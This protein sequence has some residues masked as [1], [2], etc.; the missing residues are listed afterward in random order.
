MKP[1]D[2][3]K[4]KAGHPLVTRDG[5]KARLVGH[6][7]EA[8]E[9]YRVYAYIEGQSCAYSFW[10]SGNMGGGT[11]DEDLFMAPNKREGWVNVYGDCPPHGDITAGTSPAY[12]TKDIADLRAGST[13]SA[14]IRIEWEE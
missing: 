1:F 10:E 14:C 9:P 5:R 6:V 7:P 13:R 12:S 8:V 4:A 2:L 3:E 11:N